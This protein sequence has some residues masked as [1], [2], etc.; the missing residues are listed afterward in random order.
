MEKCADFKNTS[1]IFH[2]YS[3]D[4]WNGV[5]YNKIDLLSAYKMK[6]V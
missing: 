5:L 6:D 2:N 4:L 3:I 1:L